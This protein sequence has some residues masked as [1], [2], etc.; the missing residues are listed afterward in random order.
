MLG[1]AAQREVVGADKGLMRFTEHVFAPVPRGVLPAMAERSRGAQA[2][3]AHYLAE[4]ACAPEDPGAPA[5]GAPAD[6]AGDG[7]AR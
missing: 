1:V 7:A 4:A 6:A 5:E 3:T 2:T